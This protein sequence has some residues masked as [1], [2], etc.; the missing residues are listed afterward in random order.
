MT[1]VEPVGVGV[2]EQEENHDECHEVHVDT[3][4]DSGVVKAP[5]TLDAADC[6]GGTE[7]SEDSGDDE[8]EGGAVVGEVGEWHSDGQ[9]KED[10]DVATNERALTRVEDSE[11]HALLQG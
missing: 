8:E 11:G 9:A 6:L 1:V 2:E 7:N 3:E 5:A 10:E 4:D